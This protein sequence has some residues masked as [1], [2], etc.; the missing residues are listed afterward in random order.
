[1]V[2]SG[3]CLTSNTRT[4]QTNKSLLPHI[5]ALRISI[6]WHNIIIVIGQCAFTV[7]QLAEASGIVPALEGANKTITPK[8]SQ[9]CQQKWN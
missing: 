7:Q 6:E 1:M 3:D 5:L 8:E 4:S 2:P 9:Q